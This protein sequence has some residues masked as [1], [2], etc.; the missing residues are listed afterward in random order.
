MQMPTK[1]VYLRGKALKSMPAIE[2]IK[3]KDGK[4]AM[5]LWLPV[6]FDPKYPTVRFAW[7]SPRSQELQR[8]PTGVLPDDEFVNRTVLSIQKNLNTG[9]YG[10]TITFVELQRTDRAVA[11][12]ISAW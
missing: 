6:G 2:E 3:L 1:D 7:L 4:D 11:A 10:A 5:I 8:T 9:S 12:D